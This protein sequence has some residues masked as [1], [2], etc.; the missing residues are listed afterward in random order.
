MFP[1]SLNSALPQVAKLSILYL[2]IRTKTEGRRVVLLILKLSNLLL[3]REKEALVRHLCYVVD[4]ADPVVY[5]VAVHQSDILVCDEDALL[6]NGTD[7]V[8][9]GVQTVLVL[10]IL[11]TLRWEEIQALTH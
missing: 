9:Q 11:P 1:V 4:Q 7:T 2:A 6:A 3:P 5:V 10:L 8:T